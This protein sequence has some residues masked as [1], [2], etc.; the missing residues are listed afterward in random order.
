MKWNPRLEFDRIISGKSIQQLGLVL[1]LFITVLLF[2]AGIYTLF[3]R[4]GRFDENIHQVFV[5]MTNP[6]TVRDS[7]YYTSQP[8]FKEIA[9]SEITKQPDKNKPGFWVVFGLVVVY[10]VGA[11]FF[12][13]L[14]IA[15]ITNIWRGRADKFRRGAVKYRFSN[16]IVF[17]GYHSLIAGMIQK[18]CE[19][20]HEHIKDIRIVVGVENDASHVSKKIKNRLYDRY[21]DKVVVLQADSCNM[22]DLKRL[23]VTHAK[24]VYIIGEYDDAY[25]LRSYRSIY[26]LSL[27]EKSAK[28]SMPQCYVK[29]QSQATLTLFRTYASAGDLGIDFAK[30]HSFSFY[31]EWARNVIMDLVE[32]KSKIKKKWPGYENLQ[33]HFII[34]GMTEMGIALARKAALL[35]HRPDHSRPTIITLIDDEISTKAEHFIIQHQAFF[36]RISYRIQ[37]KANTYNHIPI[38]YDNL[39]DVSF[40]FIEGNFSEKPIRQEISDSANS[41]QQVTTL[42]ICY[43]NP[44]Q[45]IITG[46]N[47]PNIFYEDNSN[48]S[49][50]LYQPT[51]GD[52]GYYMNSIRYK[53]VDT[54][55]ML[56]KDLDIQNKDNTLRAKLINHYF[57]CQKNENKNNDDSQKP[58]KDYSNQRLIN[59]EWEGTDLSER[60]ACIRRAE[61]IPVLANYIDND[62]DLEKMERQRTVVDNLLFPLPENGDPYSIQNDYS[63]Y[64]ATIKRIYSTN[65]FTF[66]K[67]EN[68]EKDQDN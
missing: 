19:E 59:T 32:K 9:Q 4:H 18:I 55:G 51:L 26:E 42:V 61:F 14:L 12:T 31:D 15:T 41:N 63:I 35:C 23:R 6:E 38:K 48:V 45:N 43:D 64:I 25:N 11:V 67:Q 10:V 39:L 30:F 20:E 52:L 16:H 58:L 3:G 47:L 46:L 50:W 44:Q 8:F 13:G 24:E 33:D 53:N 37:S 56:G 62:M 36:D 2:I 60:W 1:L 34:S 66:I 7:A 54:F 57:H 17:L 40:E 68:N 65:S 27:C 5:D 22:K 29:L 21:R 28:A 49:V